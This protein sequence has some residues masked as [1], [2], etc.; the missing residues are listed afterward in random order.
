MDIRL[1]TTSPRAD[2]CT[3]THTRSV[4]SNTLTEKQNQGTYHTNF[5]IHIKL[6]IND[7]RSST[8]LVK[9]VNVVTFHP[10]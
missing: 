10:F 2:F 4:V 7:K 8:S 5:N 9:H 1:V 3:I 6:Q